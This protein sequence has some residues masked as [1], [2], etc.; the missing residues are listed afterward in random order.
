MNADL[1]E[2][3]AQEEGTAF[4]GARAKSTRR[5]ASRFIKIAIILFLTFFGLSVLIYTTKL[6]FPSKL[7][8]LIHD[9]TRSSIV[10]VTGLY[11]KGAWIE[12]EV[13]DI[14][15]KLSS[16]KRQDNLE[17]AV[18]IHKNHAKLHGHGQIVQKVQLF[19]KNINNAYTKIGNLLEQNLLE[20]SLGPELGAKWLL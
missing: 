16:K 20:M 14:A 3:A 1:E 7:Q 2:D 8:E 10:K 4:L 15:T 9:P 5:L 13:P 12:S 19:G 11:G 17:R 18:S 6:S